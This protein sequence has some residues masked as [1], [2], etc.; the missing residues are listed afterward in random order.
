MKRVKGRQQAMRRELRIHAENHGLK[1]LSVERVNEQTLPIAM[2]AVCVLAEALLISGDT[3]GGT[4][5]PVTG[6]SIFAVLKNKPT[7]E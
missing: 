7:N 3:A 4:V 5:E 6:V 1:L 2:Y